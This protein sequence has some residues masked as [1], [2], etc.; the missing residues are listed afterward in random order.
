MTDEGLAGGVA[1][2]VP[3]DHAAS[4]RE[5]PTEIGLRL[6]SAPPRDFVV[7]I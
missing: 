6:R 5:S 1:S 7:R 4:S 3:L 2:A